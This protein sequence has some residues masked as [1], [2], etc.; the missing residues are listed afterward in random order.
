MIHST[1]DTKVIGVKYLKADYDRA[2]PLGVQYVASDEYF[3]K[4]DVISSAAYVMR[5]L[6]YGSLEQHS[7]WRCVHGKASIAAVDLRPDSDTFG[8]W[9][10]K[11]LDPQYEPGAL[12]IPGGC[13]YGALTLQD[14]T[15]LLR[16]TTP[17]DASP[18]RVMAWDSAGV[19]W[20]LRPGQGVRLDNKGMGDAISYADL[21]AKLRA[22]AA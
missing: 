3:Q 10:L 19:N 13:A 6:Y 21:M 14:S 8:A 5:G 11:C 22:E 20:G 1:L 2:S 17:P 16:Y 9:T 7:L 18:L 15:V 4:T 12:L